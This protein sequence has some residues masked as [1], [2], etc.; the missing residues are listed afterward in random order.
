MTKYQRT[1]TYFGIS[2]FLVVCVGISVQI[3]KTVDYAYMDEPFHIRQTQRYCNYDFMSWDPKITT[4]PGL[5]L[6]T[7]VYVKLLQFAISL[8]PSPMLPEHNVD[9]CSSISV[10]RSVN[11]LFAMATFHTVYRLT[12]HARTHHAHPTL[13]IMCTCILL[14]SLVV[15]LSNNTKNARKWTWH[16]NEY[17]LAKTFS[18]CFF[19]ILFFFN[20]LFYTDA[21]STFFVL[22]MYK[23]SLLQN[24]KTSAIVCIH[25]LCLYINPNF[26]EWFVFCVVS[27]KQYRVGVLGYGSQFTT[28]IFKASL[29][30]YE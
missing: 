11:I 15:L 19:P 3:N 6:V 26:I 16:D 4:P 24:W 29:S 18:I 7:L 5:Y 1:P 2:A 27:S 10:L 14:Y 28:T 12:T 30:L 17:Y 20:F 8:L 13:Q 22:Y 23:Q 21:G 25:P 9:L